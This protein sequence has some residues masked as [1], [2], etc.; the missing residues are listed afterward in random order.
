[1][2]GGGDAKNI[3]SYE[4]A[5]TKSETLTKYTMSRCSTIT[6]FLVKLSKFPIYIARACSYIDEKRFFFI[7]SLQD[8]GKTSRNF[9]V[10]LLYIQRNRYNENMAILKSK[11]SI[12]Q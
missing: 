11:V 2:G 5:V 8:F 12:Q 6:R 7:L 3:A 1:M 9:I 10:V 4:K